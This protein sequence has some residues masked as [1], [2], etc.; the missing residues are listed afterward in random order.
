MCGRLFFLGRRKSCPTRVHPA[1]VQ[2]ASDGFRWLRTGATMAGAA[3]D[4]NSL[5]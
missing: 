2:L 4:A 1:W 3:Y 5:M